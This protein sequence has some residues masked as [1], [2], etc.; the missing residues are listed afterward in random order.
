MT[1]ERLLAFT[2]AVIAIALTIMVLELR[3]PHEATL[4]ALGEVVPIFLSY[5]L[6]FV[7]I[8]IYWN[9]HHH[10]FQLVEHVNGA[11]LWAN[12]H[13]IFWLSLIPFTTAWMDETHAETM[14]V[15][16][17]GVSLLMPAIAYYVLQLVVIKAQGSDGSPLRAALGSDLKGKLSPIGYLAGIALAFV[18]PY[19]GIACYVAMALVWL[20]PDRRVERHLAAHRADDDRRA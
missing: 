14:P 20:I 3:A 18:N 4:E 15:A 19:A 11:V 2:D 5:V 9:N 13:L 6:S 8:A 7:Y 1:K 16:V 10:M 12:M 17:Y